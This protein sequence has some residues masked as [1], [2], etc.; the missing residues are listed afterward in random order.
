M[1][2]VTIYIFYVI[3]LCI[4]HYVLPKSIFNWKVCC[5]YFLSRGNYLTAPELYMCFIDMFVH[6]I[7]V[8][9]LLYFCMLY[10]IIVGYTSP[11]YFV[12]YLS[13][14][15]IISPL[16][17]SYIYIFTNMFVNSMSMFTAI[18]L[19]TSCDLLLGCTT[20]WESCHTYFLYIFCCS[21]LSIL[22][23]LHSQ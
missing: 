15:W 23:Y 13:C 17:H 10:N 18:C 22:V 2:A 1:G 21:V 5:I 11:W 8:S 4:S 3:H 6:L 20:S 14:V 16:H 19:C 9:V 7:T 12:I